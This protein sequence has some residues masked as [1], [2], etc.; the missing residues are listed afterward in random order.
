[1]EKVTLLIKGKTYEVRGIGGY[2]VL[3]Y[4]QNKLP[5]SIFCLVLL[6]CEKFSEVEQVPRDSIADNLSCILP[7]N[8]AG[9]SF[10]LLILSGVLGHRYHIRFVRMLE[11]IVAVNGFRAAALHGY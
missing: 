11:S 2:E 3:I 10:S 5:K 6:K 4:V 8:W 9:K 1:M 7:I